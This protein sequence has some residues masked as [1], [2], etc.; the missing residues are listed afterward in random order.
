MIACP[1]GASKTKANDDE[2]TNSESGEGEFSDGES[3]VI[4]LAVLEP[5]I[6]EALDHLLSYDHNGDF[7]L[8]VKNSFLS[9]LSFLFSSN[10]SDELP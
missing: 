9:F 5:M 6:Q 10:F 4:E 1:A 3:E 2:D 8:E 7:A